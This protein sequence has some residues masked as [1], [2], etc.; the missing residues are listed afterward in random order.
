M[1]QIPNKILDLIIKKVDPQSYVKVQKVNSQMDFLMPEHADLYDAKLG[2]SIGAISFTDIEKQTQT[3]LDSGYTEEE[4]MSLYS[5]FHELANMQ[6]MD[7]PKPV[8]VS[9][10]FEDEKHTVHVSLECEKEAKQ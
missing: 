6:E 9:V 7:L 1:D 2:D 4:L 5:E 10:E 8:K 3:F